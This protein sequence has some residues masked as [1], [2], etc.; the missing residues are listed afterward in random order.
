MIDDV[1]QAQTSLLD[2]QDN[3][4]VKAVGRQSLAG[5]FLSTPFSVFDGR[6]AWWQGR[7]A[8]WLRLG[9]RS[10]AGRDTEL[11]F[12]SSAQPPDVYEAKNKYEATLGRKATWKEFIE[13][14][15]GV[16]RQPG[17]SV[18]DPVLCELAYRWFSPRGGL[19]LDPFAGGRCAAWWRRCVGETM[20]ASI[21][22]PSR[23]RLTASNGP[24]SA[25]RVTGRRSGM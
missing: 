24:P 1:M 17:T 22:G 10:D 12:S 25:G 7:K 13:A 2:E 3:D 4:S 14:C 16:A 9:L 11:I 6:T 8:T 20:W 5:R 23:S 21:C 15:P 19:V 18:F